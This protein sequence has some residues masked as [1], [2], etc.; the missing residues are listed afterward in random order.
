MSFSELADLATVLSSEY[1]W[2]L[3]FV[4]FLWELFCPFPF[5][6]TKLQTVFG[7]LE[8]ETIEVRA[9]HTELQDVTDEIHKQQVHLIQIVRAIARENEDIEE[10]RVDSYLTHNGVP[11]YNFQK[12]PDQEQIERDKEQFQA[13]DD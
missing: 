6:E 10:T 7:N 13:D 9:A 12:D 8:K 3:V 4:L 2:V 11:V 5:H 1:G